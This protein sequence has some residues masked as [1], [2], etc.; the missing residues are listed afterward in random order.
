[1]KELMTQETTVFWVEPEK[2]VLLTKVGG[3]TL[4][5]KV[6]DF[7]TY[8]GRP[9]GVRISGFSSKPSEPRGP[10]GMFYI[11]W[12]KEQKKWAE[13][14]WALRGDLR[15]IIAFP[16]GVQHYGEQIIWD[17]VQLKDN[18]I[19]PDSTEAS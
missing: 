5:L 3:G 19:C 2:S 17:N 7:I 18:G 10:L 6:G 16:C 14:R 9:D 1:M 11:P 12:R 4:E 8:E 13:P 15:H